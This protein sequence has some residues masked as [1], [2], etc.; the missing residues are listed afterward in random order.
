MRRSFSIIL[1]AVQRT[2]PTFILTFGEDECPMNRIFNPPML[3]NC[4]TNLVRI[5][6][7]TSDVKLHL[8]DSLI[9]M[10]N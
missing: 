9:P 7:K 2:N 3:S 10:L 1:W 4:A 6:G 5:T 8:M